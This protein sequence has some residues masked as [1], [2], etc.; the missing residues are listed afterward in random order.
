MSESSRLQIEAD[1]QVVVARSSQHQPQYTCPTCRAAV[2]R[3]PVEIFA[4][5]EL[6]NTLADKTGETKPKKG[7]KNDGDNSKIWDGFFPL[8]LL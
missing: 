4:L 7:R 3:R 8:R 1:V 6:A 2:R 5:K